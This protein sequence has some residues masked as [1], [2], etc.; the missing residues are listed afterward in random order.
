MADKAGGKKK[1]GGGGE[2]ASAAAVPAAKEEGGGGGGGEEA[3]G[4]PAIVSYKGPTA[5]GG[6]KEGN[7]V[8]TYEDGTKYEGAFV[9]DMR[10][11]K[12]PSTHPPIQDV[13]QLIRTHPP[14]PLTLLPI[15]GKAR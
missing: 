2:A 8:A 5:K 15:Q 1:G 3:A 13:Q 4:P 12:H 14:N 7:G 6:V 10:Q 11:G 9:K